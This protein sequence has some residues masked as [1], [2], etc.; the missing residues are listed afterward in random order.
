MRMVH[1]QYPIMPER[2]VFWRDIFEHYYE[3]G[4]PGSSHVNRSF[5]LFVKLYARYDEEDVNLALDRLLKIERY[6]QNE[7]I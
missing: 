5:S 4:K 2:V 6:N 3:L 1:D 7:R